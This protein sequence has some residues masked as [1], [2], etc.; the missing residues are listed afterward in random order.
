MK[1][2][3]LQYA[4]F[5]L[6]LALLTLPEYYL[7]LL[8]EAFPSLQAPVLGGSFERV[9]Y[10]RFWPQKW[11]TGDYQGQ[12]EKARRNQS[13]IAP[14][15]VRH[16]NQLLRDVFG[17]SGAPRVVY[18]ENDF[19]YSIE[20][21]RALAG[22]DYIGRQTIQAKVEQLQRIQE[23][24]GP[25][26][27]KV[28]VLLPPGKPRVLPENLPSFFRERESESTN[29]QVFSELLS[30]SG[31]PFMNFDFLIGKKSEYPYP[32]YPQFGL[33]WNYYGATVAADSL[34]RKIGQLL[35][36]ELPVMKY[37]E[38][39][40]MRDSLMSTDKELL[41]GANIM[42]EPPAK[43]MPYPKIQYREDSL[44]FR[45]RVLIVGDSYYKIWYDYGIQ[46]GLFH[47]ESSFWYYY[48]TMFPP[49]NGQHAQS[50]PVLEETLSKDIILLP[51]AEINLNNLGFGYLDRLEAALKENR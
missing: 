35:G 34:R 28:L 2:R 42:R 12:F 6:V 14:S 30:G 9:E 17:D 40:E 1:Q 45:P 25:D 29:W 48:G 33:H 4:F 11:L 38:S 26:G 31:V 44:S 15:V 47:P 20:Y 22:M 5:L 3:G 32:I 27:P 50:L 21:C 39:V 8:Q 24:L 46:N 23:L 16:R 49:R 43:P 41:Y 37:K 13:P 19:F 10:P 7:P 51:H 18:G 36:K